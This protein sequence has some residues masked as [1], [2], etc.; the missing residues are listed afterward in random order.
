MYK[1]QNFVHFSCKL[2]DFSQTAH[3]GSR[4]QNVFCVFSLARLSSG[5]VA[6][7]IDA[8][9]IRP[10]LREDRRNNKLVIQS[11]KHIKSFLWMWVALMVFGMS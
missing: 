9:R 1:F 2:T 6:F 11:R 4:L 8:Y 3:P 7:C 10:V 5:L